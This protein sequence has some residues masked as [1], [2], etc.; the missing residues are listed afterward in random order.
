M[1]A[2]ERIGREEIAAVAR[3]ITL[4]TVY[5]LRGSLSDTEEGMEEEEQHEE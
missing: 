1:A 4:D 5:F 3:K 2:M